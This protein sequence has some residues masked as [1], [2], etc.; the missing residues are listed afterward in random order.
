MLPGNHDVVLEVVGVGAVTV[1]VVA[2]GV[3]VVVVHCQ[4]KPSKWNQ[5]TEGPVK[6]PRDIS[7][8]YVH[9]S[10]FSE[11]IETQ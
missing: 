3:I 9:F 10:L 1:S 4:K 11:N 8:F 7:N 2:V 6:K 5:T